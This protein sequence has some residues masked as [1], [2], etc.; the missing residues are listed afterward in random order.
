MQA[1]NILVDYNTIFKKSKGK[2]KANMKISAI[3]SEY[4]PF[5]SGHAYHI[6]ETRKKTKC[7][8]VIAIMS[9]NFVQRGEPAIAD[10]FTRAKWAVNHGVDAVLELPTVFACSSAEIFA[11]GAIRI[12]SQIPS[13]THLSFGCET[14]DIFKLQTLASALSNP[15]TDLRSAFND[16]SSKGNSFPKAQ[17]LA[18]EQVLGKEFYDLLSTPNNTLA[19][20]YLTAL[21]K[22]G[23]HIHPCAIER[24]GASYH[25]TE[26]NFEHPSATALRIAIEN[27]T[28]QKGMLFQDV[29]ED[30][31][32]FTTFNDEKLQNI[33][34]YLLRLRSISELSSI[35]D[36][37][38][39]LENRLKTCAEKNLTLSDTLSACKTKRYTMARLK[40][41][42][43]NVL[44]NITKEDAKDAL[45]NA[46]YAHVLA[47]SNRTPSI[48]SELA[49]TLP[50]ITKKA[51]FDHLTSTPAARSLQI[52]LR[53]SKA[54]ASIS[55]TDPLLDFKKPLQII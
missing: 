50:L 46:R 45:A 30:L 15:S 55:N 34:L 4:N 54:Y 53:G 13:V 17:A 31:T 2:Q 14:P 16:A 20:T 38:E 10:K 47:V 9:G 28:L 25:E 21:E 1:V 52:D 27:G 40:R 44:L 37:T 18:V 26:L 8:A 3:I 32:D 23:S 43:M 29:F 39:G 6:E 19:I 51:D 12:L 48:L 7:D 11:E 22:I 41:I 5:H 36:V 42:L 49:K 33:V 35:N 24:K